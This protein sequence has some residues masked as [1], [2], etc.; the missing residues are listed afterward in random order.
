MN[1]LWVVLPALLLWDS[2]SRV[3]AAS[4]TTAHRAGPSD[5]VFAMAGGGLPPIRAAS[6]RPRPARLAVLVAACCAYCSLLRLLQFVV[7]I[8]A[9]CACCLR[10]LRTEPATCRARAARPAPAAGL[11]AAYLVIVPAVL[12]TAPGVPVQAA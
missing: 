4:A 10:S 3:A 2:A 9:C 7:L 6:P 8:A 1:G 5:T 11:V 12:F